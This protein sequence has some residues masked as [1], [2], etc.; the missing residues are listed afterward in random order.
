MLFGWLCPRRAAEL[1]EGLRRRLH[2]AAPKLV[3][4]DEEKRRVRLL[5]SRH[6]FAARLPVDKVL[7]I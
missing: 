6:W 5:D 2:L 1:P 4:D 7:E 3:S